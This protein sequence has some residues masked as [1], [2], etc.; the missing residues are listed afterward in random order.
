LKS[1]VRELES[2]NVTNFS[3]YE[4]RLETINKNINSIKDENIKKEVQNDYRE[5]NTSIEN[6]L[7]VELLKWDL[8]FNSI[9]E[10]DN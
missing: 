5:L 6:F 1:K 8:F 9:S 4:K 7:F 10:I 3:T 2:L